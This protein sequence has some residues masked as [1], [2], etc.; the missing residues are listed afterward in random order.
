MCL[1]G[2]TCNRSLRHRHNLSMSF[3]ARLNPN[4]PIDG[5]PLTWMINNVV[6]IG[7]SM[8]PCLRSDSVPEWNEINQNRGNQKVRRKVGIR[9]IINAWL[10]NRDRNSK[11]NERW[12]GLLHC[13]EASEQFMTLQPLTTSSSFKGGADSFRERFYRFPP[14]CESSETSTTSAL[15]NQFAL[16]ALSRLPPSLSAKSS[17]L[18]PQAWLLLLLLAN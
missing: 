8:L 18:L 15:D 6:Y 1:W 13:C 5:E 10:F 14:L 17:L 9:E 2:A 16:S 3:D 4:L 7:Y 12:Q 11:R